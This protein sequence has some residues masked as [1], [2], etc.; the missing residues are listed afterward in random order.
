[1]QIYYDL[2]H[3][4]GSVSYRTIFFKYVGSVVGQEP[5]EFILPEFVSYLAERKRLTFL[6]TIPY[7]HVEYNVHQSLRTCRI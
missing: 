6:Y 5:I 1:M 7:E 2:W 4:T 3:E